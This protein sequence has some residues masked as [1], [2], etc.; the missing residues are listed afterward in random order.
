M[1]QD[2]NSLDI[3]KH[4]VTYAAEQLALW[5]DGQL[6]R[7]DYTY[8]GIAFLN[9]PQIVG[10]D[11]ALVGLARQAIGNST[12]VIDQTKL[13]FLPD[14][15]VPQIE[16]AFADGL[17]GTYP[18]EDDPLYGADFISIFA[19][20]MRPLGRGSAHIRS[21]DISQSP[22][23]DPQYASSEYDVRSI[24]EAGKYARRIAQTRPLADLLVGEYT[25]GLDAVWTD[26]EWAGYVRESLGTIYHY[27]GTCAMLPVGDGG[28]VDPR[29]RIWGTRNLRV[30]DASVIPVL[31]GS[32]TQTVTYGIAERAA[33]IIVE[34]F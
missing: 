12:N 23:I 11:S 9:W 13:S 18:S 14:D 27:A 1:K 31:I 16:M 6:S 34:D 32:H 4:N 15:S 26:D 22:A 10:N 2:Y 3:F 8:N 7:Y 20:G 30:V 24:V 5:E 19:I 17:I 29:L 21:S 28:V 25:P 33:E